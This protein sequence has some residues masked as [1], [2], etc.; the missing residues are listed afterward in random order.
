M[1][2]ITILEPGANFYDKSAK[3]TRI[4][5]RKF[6]AKIFTAT[7]I[8][9]GSYALLKTGYENGGIAAPTS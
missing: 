7:L 3:T 5:S 2:I 1:K 4:G 9:K 6:V 8:V